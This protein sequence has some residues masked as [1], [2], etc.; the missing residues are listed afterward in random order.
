M[1]DLRANFKLFFASLYFCTTE[2]SREHSEEQIIT[3][4]GHKFLGGKCPFSQDA[5]WIADVSHYITE[6]VPAVESRTFSVL[7]DCNRVE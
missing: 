3:F 6:K 7:S 1:F 4:P 5:P 2:E